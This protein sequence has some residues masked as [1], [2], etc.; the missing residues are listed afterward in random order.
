[1][2]MFHY[3]YLTLALGILTLVAAIATILAHQGKKGS[4]EKVKETKRRI[5][6]PKYTPILSNPENEKEQMVDHLL[7]R[8]SLTLDERQFIYDF[9]M[10]TGK[11]KWRYIEG[12]WGYY[13][14]SSTG[15]VESC[16]R[17]TYLD[18]SEKK[19]GYQVILSV[20]REVK[21]FSIHKLVAETFIPNP[22]DAVTVVPK[23]GDYRHCDVRNLMWKPKVI[24]SKVAVKMA[25]K[26]A[27]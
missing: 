12:Y 10:E 15:M 18:P 4:P 25:M 24:P 7:K 27:A 2:Y 19:N 8:K 3:E 16:R 20:N 23:D 26:E 22:S 5:Y 14:I 1:M 9:L 11:E 21:G 13:R 17:H 6:P